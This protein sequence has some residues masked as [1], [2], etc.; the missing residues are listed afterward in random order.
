MDKEWLL[1]LRNAQKSAGDSTA[2]ISRSS[3][4]NC[5][6][7]S[8]CLYWKRPNVTWNGLLRPWKP[9]WAME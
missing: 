9:L 2:S 4:K 7:L 6:L 1:L 3:H 5:V 8:F